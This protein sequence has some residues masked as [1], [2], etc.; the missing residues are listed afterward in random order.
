MN[1]LAR[2]YYSLGRHA[3]SLKLKEKTLALRTAKLGREHSDTLSTM[4]NLACSYGIFG[5]IRDAIDLGEETVRLKK[6][7]LGPEHPDTL[8]SMQNLA[9]FYATGMRSA[10]ALA[11]VQQVIAVRQR[12]LQSEAGNLQDRLDLG[13]TYGLLGMAEQARHDHAAGTKAY[14]VSVEMFEKLDRA[15]ELQDSVY[16]GRLNE[17]R[18][19][20]GLCRKAE[21]AMHDLNFALDQPAEEVSRLL[22]WRVRFL[23]DKHELA[24]AVESAAKAKQFTGRDKDRLYDTACLYAQCAAAAKGPLVGEYADEAMSLL[25]QAVANG[26]KDGVRV[27]QDSDLVSLRDRDDFKKLLVQLQEKK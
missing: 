5:R 12:R 23:L 21:R 16:R 22:D 14:A 17:S 15:G 1:D 27:A 6:A 10:D 18:W 9:L 13:W 7:K 20:L 11:L 24:A 19:R 25:R 3:D 26:L 4:E 2:C 8:H